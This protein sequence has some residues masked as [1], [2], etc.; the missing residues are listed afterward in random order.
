M[1]HLKIQIQNLPAHLDT[2]TNL[3]RNLFLKNG[4]EKLEMQKR[5]KN[6]I[7]S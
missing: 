4:S 2:E 3:L 7:I 5:T 6:K 1:R